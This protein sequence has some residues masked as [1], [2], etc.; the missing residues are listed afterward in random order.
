MGRLDAIIDA[1][2]ALSS[3]AAYAHPDLPSAISCI[4]LVFPST[5]VALSVEPDTDEL[6]IQDQPYPGLRSL[7]LAASVSSAL[8][9]TRLVS[10]WR[11]QNNQGYFDGIQL[12]FGHGP[13]K[14]STIVQVVAA[15]SM[16]QIFSVVPWK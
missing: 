9:R 5:Q 13:G 6:A 11:M 7:N 12:E 16:L 15:A 1:R 2:E 14:G 10:V 8:L 4:Q 3:I